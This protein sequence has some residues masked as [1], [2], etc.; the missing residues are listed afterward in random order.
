MRRKG[1][2]E[3]FILESATLRFLNRHLFS[4]AGMSCESWS[5]CTRCSSAECR[6][7]ISTKLT[8]WGGGLEIPTGTA[9]TGPI[10]APYQGLL[11]VLCAHRPTHLFSSTQTPLSLLSTS[12]LMEEWILSRFAAVMIGRELLSLNYC[13]SHAHAMACC[14]VLRSV[15]SFS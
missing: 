2:E 10:V 1:K 6:Y 12:T 5:L 14:Y 11:F 9:W 8:R 4:R 15:E 7:D 3:D 13:Q